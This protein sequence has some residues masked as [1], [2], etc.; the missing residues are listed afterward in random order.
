MVY[1]KLVTQLVKCSTVFCKQKGKFPA[2]SQFCTCSDG[3]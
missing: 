2:I 3:H 1:R